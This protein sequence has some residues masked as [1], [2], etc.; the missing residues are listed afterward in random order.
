MGNSS[1]VPAPTGEQF[2]SPHE[3]LNPPLS[4]AVF[5]GTTGVSF[6]I[7]QDAWTKGCVIEELGGLRVVPDETT[8]FYEGSRCTLYLQDT[9]VAVLLSYDSIRIRVCTFLP[10]VPSSKVQAE[11]EGRPLYEYAVVTKKRDSRQH[12]LH[13]TALPRQPHNN[14]QPRLVTAKFKNCLPHE[15][16]IHNYEDKTDLWGAIYEQSTTVWR[17]Q[18]AAGV[19]PILLLAFVL[20]TDRFVQY[21]EVQHL[22]RTATLNATSQ[23]GT[24]AS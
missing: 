22:R 21:V 11:H 23:V 2:E 6:T 17:V 15:R 12:V 16:A 4:A 5:T 20:A 8:K 1:S 13:M 19:D 7:P 18:T 14:L 3:P 9:C 10:I 24:L